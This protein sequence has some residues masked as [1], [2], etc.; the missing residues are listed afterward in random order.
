M[1]VGYE[2]KS[3]IEV[4]PRMCLSKSKNGETMT[5]MGGA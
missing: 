4:A 5:E 3:R 2:R 1:D